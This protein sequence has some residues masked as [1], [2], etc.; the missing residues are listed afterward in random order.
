MAEPIFEECG[1]CGHE[2]W[3]EPESGWCVECLRFAETG[4]REPGT[5]E[6]LEAICNRIRRGDETV[7]IPSVGSR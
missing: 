6:E 7:G 4:E 1:L 3:C 5:D 2:E